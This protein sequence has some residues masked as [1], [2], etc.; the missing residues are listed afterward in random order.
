MKI[1]IIR[2]FILGS[3]RSGSNMLR[4]M[5][6]SSPALSAPHPPH[7]LH[8]FTP[9]LP[10]YGDLAIDS[11][12]QSLITDV[13]AYTHLSPVD[14]IDSGD[15]LDP[16]TVADRCHERSLP[17]LHDAVYSL[18]MEAN[19][20]RAWVCKSNDN[21]HYLEAIDEA[22]GDTARYLFLV[23]DGRDVALSYRKAPIGPKHP[24][25]CA[26]E[27]ETTQRR[28]LAWE[29]HAVGRCLRIHY[30]QLLA[31][32][33]SSLRQIC[34][35]LG[36]DYADSMLEF[37]NTGEA[38]R[39]SEKSSLWANLNQPILRN[40]TEKWRQDSLHNVQQFERQA[41]TTLTELGYG[42]ACVLLPPPTPNELADIHAEDQRLRIEVLDKV[43]NDGG[44]RD[45]QAAFLAR[46]RQ[47]LGLG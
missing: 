38:R 3:R 22:F 47:T 25:V 15:R 46:H 36:V 33:E 16:D 41:H 17:W 42:A 12:W 11:N 1:P 44:N 37:H 8:A 9:I 19:G 26:Q 24:Y 28:M 27:W 20:K 43:G 29:R 5:L 2:G 40:N 34:T 10:L 45:A 23:R 6:N 30:E 31:D 18:I 7:I 4:V 21:I 32:P 35:F 39:T 13:L 14:L